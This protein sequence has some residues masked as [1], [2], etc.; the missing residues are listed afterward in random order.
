LCGLC[1]CFN[2]ALRERRLRLRVHRLWPPQFP[3][4]ETG[5]A[6]SGACHAAGRNAGQPGF[7]PARQPGAA[8]HL[9]CISVRPGHV[10]GLPAARPSKGLHLHPR[11]AAQFRLGGG[12]HAGAEA[13]RLPPTGGAQVHPGRHRS[14]LGVQGDGS[15]PR[16]KL[17]PGVRMKDRLQGRDYRFIAV[18]LALLAATTWF[19]VGNFYRAFPEASIDFR[20]NRDEGESLAASFLGQQGYGIVGYRHASSF[21]FDDDAKTFLER[22]AGLEQANQLMG[23]KVRLWRWSYRWF[24]PLQKEEYNVDITPRGELAAFSHQIPEDAAGKETTAEQARILAEDFL[25][26]RLHRDPATLEFVEGSDVA[27]PHRTDRVFTWKERDFN[28][29]DATSRVEVTLLGGEVGGYRE[30]L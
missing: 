22:E 9:P 11:L 2:A 18:C 12:F 25:R 24:R 5:A 14:S 1:R 15:H 4:F 20:V 7:L 6:G 13:L 10:L 16:R 3:G 19:S 30:Y 27:R 29:H 28:L 23:T 8:P 21:G 17:P 26:T